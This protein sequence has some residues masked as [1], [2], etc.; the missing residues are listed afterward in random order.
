M[1]RGSR[2]LESGSRV[3][4]IGGGPAGSLFALYLLHYGGEKGIHPKVTIYNL[5]NFDEPGPK[6]CKGCAGILSI[7]L[8]RNLEQLGLIMPKGIIQTTIE[9]YTVHSPYTSI[10]ISNPEKGIQIASVYRGCGALKSHSEG[11]ISFDGWL[12]REAQNRGA[13]VENQKVSSAFL[14]SEPGVNIAGEKIKHD[15]VV[16]AVGVN[17]RPIRIL[18]SKYIPPKVRVMDRD[19]LYAGKAQV[20]QWLGNRAHVFLVP[21]SS[22]IFGTLV[23]KGPFISVSVLGSGKYPVSVTDFLTYDLVRRILPGQYTRSC[24]CRPRAVVGAARNYYADGFVAIGDA[25]VSRFYKDGIG[26]AL[27]TAREAARTAVFDGISRHDFDRHYQPFCGR[28]NRDNLWGRILFSLNNRVKDSKAFLLAQHRLI[29]D[30]QKNTGGLQPFTKAAWGMFTGSYHYRRIA[31]MTLSPASLANLFAAWLWERLG[32]LFGKEAIGPRKLLVGGRKVLILG[33]GFGGTYA[34]RHL[35][36]SLNRNENVEVTMVSE[37]NFF[38]FSPL[39]HEVAMGGI[40]PR[41]IAYPIRRLHGRDRFNFSQASVEKIDLQSRKITTTMGALDFD[42]LIL[43]LGSVPNMSELP[44]AGKQVFTLKTLYDSIYIRSHIIRVFES[45]SVVRDQG[46]QRPLLTFIISGAGYTGVQLV[47]ELRDFIHRNLVRFYKTIDPGNIRIILV[48]S[49]P[50]IIAELH[51]KLGS[52]VMKHL[53]KTG[54]EVRLH[55][56]ITRVGQDEVEIN[57]MESVPASTLIWAAGVV[58]NP[59]IAELDVEKDSMGRILVNEFLEIPGFPGVYGV[60]DC[61][62]FEDPRT[63][64]PIPPRAHTAVRQA[65][66]VAFNILAEIRG[67]DKKP[68]RYVNTAEMVS[69]G[70]SKAVFRF[71]GF[72]IYGLAARIMWLVGYS[73]L[74][75]GIY[76]RS[77]VV[78]DWLLSFLFGRDTTVLNLKKDL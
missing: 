75:A 62:H 6:G 27:L 23:P 50:K 33:S 31:W 46:R 16:L 1:D 38:L 28:L 63:G 48:E 59:R 30:E 47:T 72:R 17:T 35:V 2:K 5:R 77:R 11:T 24:G 37:E 68:Y 45:A 8:L 65:K 43:A 36:P 39:L 41:H 20:E 7:P 54:I 3:G 67:R 19:E 22:L 60:G 4:I 52:Y 58:A 40:E 44:F 57:G 56:R 32:G 25:A 76:N 55:S 61:A 34:L 49:E 26:S 13:I 12:L 18:G 71:H 74:V 10:S 78:M 14:G 15:L 21:H 9:Q 51:T 69:L 53:Q 64:Q 29:G 73:L 42:Y 70:A 66:I